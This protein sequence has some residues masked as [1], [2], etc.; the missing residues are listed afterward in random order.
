[1]VGDDF[2][3]FQELF[4]R[5][6]GS[7]D[8]SL[9][10]LPETQHK[11]QD[12]LQVSPTAKIVLPINASIM[13]PAKTIWQTPATVPPSCKMSDKKYYVLSKGAE[14]L[15]IHPTPNLLVI[16]A[17]SQKGKQHQSK[18]TPSDKDWKRLDSFR[19]KAYSFTMLQFRIANYSALLVKYTHNLF[20]KMSTFIEH[21]P[22]DKREMFK[23]N[24]SEGSLVA[25][26]ARQASLNSADMAAW[27][28]TTYVVMCRAS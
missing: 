22:D 18:T 28:F 27:S 7:L 6:T 3:S 16:E 9:S 19:R 25:R 4:K 23:A 12:I 24:I 15:F 13:D 17:V 5:V 14:F 21:L 2:K 11:L 10:A 20:S 1:M 26:T 8:I